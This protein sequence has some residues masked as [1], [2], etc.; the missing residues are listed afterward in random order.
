M[1]CFLETL[2]C[3]NTWPYTVSISELSE[4]VL[5]FHTVWRHQARLVAARTQFQAVLSSPQATVQPQTVEREKDISRR[6]RRKRKTYGV[7]GAKDDSRRSRLA[8]W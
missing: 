2:S 8:T 4:T 5:L 6:M 7:L 3:L 1:N